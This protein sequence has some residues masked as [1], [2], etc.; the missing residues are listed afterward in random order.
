MDSQKRMAPDGAG[1]HHHACG[2]GSEARCLAH[3]FQ[4]NVSPFRSIGEANF[5]PDTVEAMTLAFD[6]ARGTL[7]LADK[8]D[9]LSEILAHR[10]VEIAKLGER[11]AKRICELALQAS[12]GE[13]EF[14]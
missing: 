14:G 4:E 3:F 9:P 8:D 10:I 11:D 5:D 7:G 1:R 12:T 2:S 6:Q 13:Y